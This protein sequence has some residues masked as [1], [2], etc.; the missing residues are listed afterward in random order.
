MRPKS[1]ASAELVRRLL[2]DRPDLAFSGDPAV[3]TEEA[4][5]S[6]SLLPPDRGRGVTTVTVPDEDFESLLSYLKETRAS[7]SPA[8]SAPA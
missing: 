7:T 1:H 6:G 8:T 4:D 2:M 3:L 5:G